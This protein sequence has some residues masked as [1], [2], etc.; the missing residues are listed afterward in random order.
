[1]TQVEALAKIEA[2]GQPFFETKDLAAL[3]G[4]EHSN[5]NKIATRLAR[6]GLIVQLARG[7]WAFRRANKLAVPEHLT[8]P[9]PTYISLQTALYYH[10]MLSQI[11]SVTYAVSLAR[12]RQYETVFGK[13]SIHHVDPDFFFG[14]ET[15]KSGSAKIAVPEKALLDVFY[16]SPTRTRLFVRLPEIEFPR[17]FSWRTAF[18]IATKIKSPARRTLV[19]K[20][21]TSARSF[22][23]HAP[24]R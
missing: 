17:G 18:D 4:V 12:S 14:Y 3:L 6:S 9:Y 24:K 2:L 11:P 20:C 8:S 10:G 21:L 15:D 5:A 22:A 16:L 19:K 23:K 1:M 13:F 7:K